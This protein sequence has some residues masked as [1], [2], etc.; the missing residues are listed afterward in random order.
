MQALIR[1]TV[2]LFVSYPIL[3]L[4]FIIAELLDDGLNSLRSL[5][6]KPLIYW[7]ATRHTAFGSEFRDFDKT[8]ENKVLMVSHLLVQGTHYLSALLTATA[9]VLT[10]ALVA[11]VLRGQKPDLATAVSV[12]RAYPR[13]IAVYAAKNWA[14]GMLLFALVGFPVSSLLQAYANPTPTVWNIVGK[15]EALLTLPCYAWIMAPISLAFLRPAGSAAV[16]PRQRQQARYFSILVGVAGILL[17][18]LLMPLL[19]KLTAHLPWQPVLF[20]LGSLLVRPTS[21]LLYIGLAL[22]A[23][24][25]SMPDLP[26]LGPRIKK[27]LEPLMPLHFRSGQEAASA[28]GENESC[29]HGEN[30]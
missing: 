25:E 18:W 16:S 12:L 1:K 17:S 5:T 4:P 2:N 27:I 19:I 3:W 11:L 10:G 15:S 29:V 28:N 26:P 20:S 13:R 8:A 22:I 30:E 21:V 24:E 14:L 23:F 7:F 9:L 6:T